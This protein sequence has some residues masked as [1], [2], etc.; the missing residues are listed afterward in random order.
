VEIGVLSGGEGVRRQAGRDAG[1]G[2]AAENGVL[3]LD[4]AGEEPE[5]G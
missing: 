3:E 1:G 4:E 5:L 2:K